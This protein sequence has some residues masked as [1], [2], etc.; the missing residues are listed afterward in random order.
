MTATTSVRTSAAEPARPV[1]RSIGELLSATT[2]DLQELFRLE[3]ELAK[4]ELQENART[5]A[6][7][8][9]F[10]GAGGLLAYLA[11]A[12]MCFAAAWGLANVMPT[13]VAFLIV[14]VVVALAAG[15]CLLAGRSRLEAFDAV[16]VQTV[17]TIK[18]DVQWAEQ[19]RN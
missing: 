6:R 9:T 13:G 3:I 15:V 17:E 10:L 8:G 11:L 4:T 7:A 5:A 12:L 18:E 16:P 1:D 14:G 19:L 2:H